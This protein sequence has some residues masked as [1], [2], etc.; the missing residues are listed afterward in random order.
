MTLRLNVSSR[1]LL[2]S[3]ARDIIRKSHK[4]TEGHDK[5]HEKI[6]DMAV[7]LVKSV[8]PEADLKV[9]SKYNM[10]LEISRG[11]F[12]YHDSSDVFDIQFNKRTGKKILD[13]DEFTS[14]KIKVPYSHAGYN[15]KIYLASK[16]LSD[17]MRQYDLE[18]TNYTKEL[19]E[20]VENYRQV[21]NHA[22]TFEQLIEYWPEAAQLSEQ[23]I[24]K[25][26]VAISN[27][28]IES[29]RAESLARIKAAEQAAK[30]AAKNLK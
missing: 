24:E 25:L 10:V 19:N 1:N 30:K 29:I 4:M 11:N 17:A 16:E 18:D 12:R 6:V 3:H 7:D 22:K 15:S 13:R 20:K 27:E 26:P 28:V 8:Y 21:I 9:L 5:L 2:M 14:I 23:L